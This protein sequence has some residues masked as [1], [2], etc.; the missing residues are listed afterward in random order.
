MGAEFQRGHMRT[1]PKKQDISGTLQQMAV[2][3]YSIFDMQT[4]EFNGEESQK[5]IVVLITA[6]H[7]QCG[8]GD[9]QVKRR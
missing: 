6:Q 7:R 1:Q 9:F 3:V 4:F 5:K 8:L 2:A